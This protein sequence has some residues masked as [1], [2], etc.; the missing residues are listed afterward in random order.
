LLIKIPQLF[1]FA[2]TWSIGTTT[3]LAGREKFDKWLRER[4]PK[5]GVTD[6]PEAKMVYDYK[7]DTKTNSWIS[8]FDTIK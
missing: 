5:V 2:F 8:W 4:L 1:V 7:Y 3:T 6:F